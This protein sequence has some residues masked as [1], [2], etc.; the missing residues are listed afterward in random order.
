MGFDAH[1][2]KISLESAGYMRLATR[3]KT[4]G[5]DE[6]LSCV[7]KQARLCRVERCDHRGSGGIGCVSLRYAVIVA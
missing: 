1:P 6:D 4:D 7:E 2:S 5:E 3:W